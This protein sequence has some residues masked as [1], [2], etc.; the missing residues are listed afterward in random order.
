MHASLAASND[1]RALSCRLFEVRRYAPRLGPRD[2]DPVLLAPLLNAGSAQTQFHITP[3]PLLQARH[4]TNPRRLR[5]I[6]LRISVRAAVTTAEHAHLPAGLVRI[7]LVP[8]L[9]GNLGCC[10]I[11]TNG[12][13][14]PPVVNTLTS[15]KR[16]QPGT[17]PDHCLQL[18]TR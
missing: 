7:L 18:A 15:I 6:Y 14:V 5:V 8:L 13:R 17:L 9:H 1:T 12:I 11:R 2:P 16:I 4:L 3:P 10:R